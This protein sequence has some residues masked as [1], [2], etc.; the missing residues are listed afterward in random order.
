MIEK[1]RLALYFSKTRRQSIDY[2][3]VWELDH[4]PSDRQI[5]VLTT[6]L[7]CEQS[8][9]KV[10]SILPPLYYEMW[11]FDSRI[12]CPTTLQDIL[13]YIGQKLASRTSDYL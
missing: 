13:Y 12:V 5:N 6:V 2:W 3:S 1:C 4:R 11:W 10:L 8:I 7:V 9:Q